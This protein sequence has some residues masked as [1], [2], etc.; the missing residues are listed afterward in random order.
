MCRRNSCEVDSLD[1]S[2][3]DSGMSTLRSN[4]GYDSERESTDKS[5]TRTIKTAGSNTEDASD[6]EVR[7]QS[8][9]HIPCSQEVL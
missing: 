2:C 7:E 1:E 6:R 9:V 5:T 8:I 3:V 4:V